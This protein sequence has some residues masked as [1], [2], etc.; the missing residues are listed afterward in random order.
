[1]Q[2]RSSIRKAAAAIW[3]LSGAAALATGAIPFL[4]LYAFA[5]EVLIA[6]ILVPRLEHTRLRSK[7]LHRVY[8]ANCL[9]IM[10]L[11][12]GMS[13]GYLRGVPIG[14]LLLVGTPGLLLGAAL[15]NPGE[16]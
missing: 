16:V 3:L 15:K 7:T 9:V 8:I 10:A 5:A 14:L 12:G 2:P 11:G 4:Y 13:S 1:V 6:L